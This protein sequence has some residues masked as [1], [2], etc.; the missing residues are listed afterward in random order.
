M[1]ESKSSVFSTCIANE[2]SA[3]IDIRNHAQETSAAGGDSVDTEQPTAHNKYFEHLT[4]RC[5]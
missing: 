1:S 3:R 4:E 5:C 2:I